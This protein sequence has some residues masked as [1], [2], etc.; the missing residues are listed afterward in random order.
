MANSNL[1]GWYSATA[2]SAYSKTTL[3]LSS[4]LQ[5]QL[6]IWFWLELFEAIKLHRAVL[7]LFT[8]TA[9][10]VQITSH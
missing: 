3:V 6:G 5:L 7:Y 4:Y 2:Y 1:H 8:V 10:Y 9:I